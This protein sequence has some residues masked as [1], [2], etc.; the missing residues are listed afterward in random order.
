MSEFKLRD[1]SMDFSVKMIPVGALLL[2][3]V[4]EWINLKTGV[5]SPY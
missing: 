1:L 5:T 4:K 3:K 2:S